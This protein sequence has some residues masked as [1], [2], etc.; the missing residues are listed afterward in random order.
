MGRNTT[1]NPHDPTTTWLDSQLNRLIWMALI[2]G[3][4]VILPPYAAFGSLLSL[5]ALYALWVC[6]FRRLWHSALQSAPND[7]SNLFGM[8]VHDKA[9]RAS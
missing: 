9:I 8:H 5:G 1:V 7:V 3:P 2:A 4:T 6:S